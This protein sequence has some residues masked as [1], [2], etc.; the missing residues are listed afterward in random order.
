PDGSTR[1]RPP[2]GGASLTPRRRAGV[3]VPVCRPEYDIF[4]TLFVI[5]SLRSERIT[6]E[7]CT[8]VSASG[9]LGGH[10]FAPA[11]TARP[12]RGRGPRPG[13]RS[14]A[15]GDAPAAGLERRRDTAL[16]RAAH[17]E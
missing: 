6:R 9:R 3:L 7:R 8:A 4:D 12:G 10:D 13:P 17:P 15:S 11:D 5:E 14:P 1:H 16:D 2:F